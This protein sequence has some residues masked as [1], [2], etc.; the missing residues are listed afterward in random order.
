MAVKQNAF[1]HAPEF[2][3]A[4]EAVERSLYMDDCLTGADSV[5]EAADLYKQLLNH[6]ERGRFLL[7]K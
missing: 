3:K 5:E 7:C 2:P 1:N 4:A 6:F